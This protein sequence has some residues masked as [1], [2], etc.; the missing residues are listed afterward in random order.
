MAKS[1]K[2]S[3]AKHHEPR[4]SWP[5]GRPRQLLDR[6]TWLRRGFFDGVRE[7]VDVEVA[8]EN[9]ILG[10]LWLR[11][12]VAIPAYLEGCVLRIKISGDSG[13]VWVDGFPGRFKHKYKEGNL[14]MWYPSDPPEK[15]WTIDKGLLALIDLALVHLFKERYAKDHP[16]EP[17]LGDEVPHAP[18]TA[19]TEQGPSQ[20]PRPTPAKAPTKLERAA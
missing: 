14:C 13:R 18:G 7:R 10:H 19:K 3:K 5:G 2:R 8:E 20:M 6:A 16:D 4:S 1:R 15:K 9:R 12:P 11:V 17:W